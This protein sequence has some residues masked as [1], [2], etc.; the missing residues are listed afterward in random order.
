[1][2]VFL[3]VKLIYPV[4][5]LVAALKTIAMA[6]DDIELKA[7]PDLVIELQNLQCVGRDSQ[8]LEV[9]FVLKNN[10]TRAITLAERWN[11]WGHISGP[12][13]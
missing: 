3:S 4:L 2:S 11:S 8:T 6:E 5:F 1:M 13:N 9:D 7:E 10:S 12:L